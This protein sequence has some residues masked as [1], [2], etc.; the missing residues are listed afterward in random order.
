M[1]IQAIR[2]TFMMTIVGGQVKRTDFGL[3][4]G[5]DQEIG[6]GSVEQQL[7]CR[8]VPVGGGEVNRVKPTV[9]PE[10]SVSTTLRKQK[11]NGVRNDAYQ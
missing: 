11:L 3:N 8:L 5:A 6:G 2:R 1:I 9:I 10:R 7:E 4:A